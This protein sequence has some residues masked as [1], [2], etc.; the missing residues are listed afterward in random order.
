MYGKVSFGTEN[1][2]FLEWKKL[3]IYSDKKKK[4]EQEKK[5]NTIY[6]YYLMCAG[7][8]ANDFYNNTILQYKS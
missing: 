4:A 8:S 7:R 6:S 3:D 5:L 2:N 1:I